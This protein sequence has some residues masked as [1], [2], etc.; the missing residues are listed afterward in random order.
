MLTDDFLRE[1]INVGEVDI[2]IGVPT[3]NHAGTV[4]QV[5]QAIRAGLLQYFPRQRAVIINADGGSKDATQE[6]V[7]AASIS[8]LQHGPNLHALRTL[9]SISTQYPGG[10]ASGV[11]LHTILAAAELLRAST[12][13]VIS[14]DSTN[15]E[16]EWLESLLRPVCRDS[17]DLVTPLYRRHKFDGLLV[18][19]LVYPMNRALYSRRV[20]EP[21]PAEFAFSGRLGSYF[22]GQEFWS[23]E[24]GRAGAEIYLTISAITGDFRL[25]Q[26]FLGTKSRVEHAPADLVPAMRQTVGVLFWSLEQNFPFWGALSDSQAIPA[27]GAEHEVSLEPIRVNR[28]RLHQMFVH[29]VAEL[30]PVLKSILTAPTLAELQRAAAAAEEDFRYSNELWVQTVYEFAASYHKTVISRDHI[31]QALVPLYRGKTH[32]FLLENHDASADEVESNVEALCL[33]FERFKPYLLE[34]WDGRK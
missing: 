6:L 34:Q 7:R 11:A 17:F 25:A 13:A 5:V 29:G 12:C 16:P 24:V 28:K 27:I 32:T 26:S 22:L 14:P 30:E 19:N 9:H 2:L 33:A 4:G 1:L 10:P 20:R 31:V 18:R 8:D 3:Y 15:I 21:Y 23:Q